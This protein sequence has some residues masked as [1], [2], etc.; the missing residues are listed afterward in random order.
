VNVSEVP[1][2][3]N[4]DYRD[5][6]FPG[7]NISAYK[8]G[9]EP[10][11]KIRASKLNQQYSNSLDWDRS[12]NMLRGGGLG[13]MWA[14]MEQHTDQIENTIEQMHPGLY[15]MKANADDNPTR[16]LAGR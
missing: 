10:T 7:E 13:A 6:G 15:S 11:Q 2:I 5:I 3:A 14:E 16:V 9:R 8:C 12:V 1:H 4:T